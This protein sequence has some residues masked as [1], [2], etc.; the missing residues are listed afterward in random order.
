LHTQAISGR[1]GRGRRVLVAMSGGVDSSV[2]AALLV[3]QGYEVIGATMRLWSGA[4]PE[5]DER[6]CCS[7]SA[8]EDA[9]RVASRLGI[10][11]Y[12][13]DFEALF[14]E[15]VVRD[16]V[17]EY[18]S[19]RTP[20]PCIRCNQHLKF[21]AL[22]DRARQLGAEHIATGHYARVGFD[23]ATGRYRLR[24][25][26]DRSKDQSYAL[27]TLTQEQLAAVL[28]PLGEWTKE[29]TRRRAA[30]LGLGVARKRDSQEICFVPGNDYGGFLREWQPTLAAPGKI[31]D[32]S[33]CVL[34]EHPGVCFFTIGQKRGLKLPLPHPMYVVEIIAE[35]NTLVV[36]SEADLMRR[37]CVVEALNWIA[38]PSL[39]GE[40]PVMAKVRYNM[41]EQPAVVRELPGGKAHLEFVQAQRAITP[42]QAAVFYHN[43]DVVGGGTV[44]AAGLGELESG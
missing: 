26:V 2:A 5:A 44:S 10:P 38:W 36:G 4:S 3:E 28:F 37:S 11:Y 14:E 20:N 1:E 19:G 40:L 7:L 29:Q 9:R 24:R 21:A 41:G 17:C 39:A 15:R 6:A 25:G 18:A 8:V 32:R 27:Y 43:D 42:G 12:V 33:G 23:E 31:V 34:G 30:E 13:L 16:F 22:L 35:T